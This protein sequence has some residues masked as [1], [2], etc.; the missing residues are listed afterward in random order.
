MTA[1]SCSLKLG[2]AAG[3][4]GGAAGGAASKNGGLRTAPG[5]QPGRGTGGQKLKKIENFENA[6][7]ARKRSKCMFSRGKTMF[8]EFFC[9]F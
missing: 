2:G 7:N 4:A 6:G 1:L 5:G 8:F 3:G 9:N